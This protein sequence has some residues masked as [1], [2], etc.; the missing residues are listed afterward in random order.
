MASFDTPV[1]LFVFN[2]PAP[3]RRV[4]ERIR[5]Q[6][7]G[8]LLLIADG[9][10]NAGER[11]LTDAARAAVSQIDWPCQVFRNF[12]DSNLG[13]R[14]RIS[15]GID[16]VFTKVP[17]TIILED[18]CV[19]DDS[20]FPFCAELLE[21]YRENPRVMMIS[22]NN[23][24]DGR[25]VGPASYYFSAIT[26]IWGWATWR[27]A[28]S[29]FDVR[30]SQWPEHREGPLLDQVFPD[31]A[32][33]AYQRRALDNVHGGRV[34]TWDVQWAFAT[35]LAGGLAVLP[36]RNLVSNIGFGPEATHTR[37]A[38]S[39]YAAMDVEPMTFP[40]VHPAEPR[41]QIEADMRSL[42]EMV[43]ERAI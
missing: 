33:V 35:W 32:I 42:A 11:R 38:A 41:R 12:A 13:C 31:P 25:Q 4:F 20:F 22:G 27:R 5:A 18:D 10:R 1:A 7:P 28:W 40:L 43:G 30:V 36:E 21:R 14:Q 23:F 26:H 37:K 6:R 19:P 24:Q 3:T 17:E 39:R 16:W 29:H 9:P 34:D 8:T 15:S 2:R